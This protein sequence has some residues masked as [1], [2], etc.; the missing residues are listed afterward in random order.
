MVHC[1][2]RLF[3]G[4]PKLAS[5]LRAPAWFDERRVW[6][7]AALLAM[8]LATLASVTPVSATTF[9]VRTNGNDAHDGLTPQTAFATIR[10]AGQSLLNPGDRAIVGPGE[11]H[12]GNIAPRRGGAAG[13]PVAFIA[14]TPGTMT[15]DPPGPVV[16]LP[17]R[18]KSASRC[19]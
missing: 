2:R 9:Y 13:Q 16:I 17:V 4:R 15:G 14:D 18:V 12:E 10:H 1:F 8:A 19:R 6:C 11:Y 3:T 5:G 7:A